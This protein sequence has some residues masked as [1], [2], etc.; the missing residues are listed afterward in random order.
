MNVNIFP[1]GTGSARL[2]ANYLLG[3][4]DHSGKTRSVKPELL[5]GNPDTLCAI[6]DSTT[7]VHKYTSGAIAFRD[8]EH[9]T[10]EQ[11]QQVIEAFRATFLP[12]L[13]EGENY[14]D[15]WV[16]HRDK[17]NVELHFLYAN[18]ELTTGKQLNIHPPGQWNIDFFNNFTRVVNDSLGYA[19]VVADPLKAALSKLDHKSPK[20]KQSK[21]AKQLIGRDLA[22]KILTGKVTNRD[23]LIQAISAYMPVMRVG[24]NYIT[25]QLPGN[26]KG[27]RL[28]GP[29]FTEGSDYQQLNEQHSQSKIPKFLTP[30]EAKAAREKLILQINERAAFNVIAY[31]KPKK[32]TY[33]RKQQTTAAKKTPAKAVYGMQSLTLP[34]K[35]SATAT[36]IQVELKEPEQKTEPAPVRPIPAIQPQSESQDTSTD[37]GS[38]GVS[39]AGLE[40]QIGSLNAQIHNLRILI[41]RARGSRLVRLQA[42]LIALEAQV[43]AL[44]LELQQARKTPEWKCPI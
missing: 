21:D 25:V 18:T 24:H 1:T 39:T 9:P 12:G 42:K 22:R 31:L 40:A 36:T 11:V 41:Q 19:Q 33:R 4:K 30:E 29:L 28:K 43:S 23:E 32:Q 26:T 6:A 37:E 3:N 38:A 17:G 5:H 34:S 16:M 2:A 14:A 8:N 44:N 27:T 20:F 15:M 13:K 35:D 7:R 10:P